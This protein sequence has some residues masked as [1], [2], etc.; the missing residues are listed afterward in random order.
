MAKKPPFIIESYDTSDKIIH[1]EGYFGRGR[2]LSIE[3][4]YDDVEHEKV[5]IDVAKMVTILNREWFVKNTS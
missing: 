1:I 3:V 4:D 5:D 2:F